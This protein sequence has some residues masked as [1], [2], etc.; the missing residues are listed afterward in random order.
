MCEQ[1]RQTDKGLRTVEE[2][3]TETAAP[4]FFYP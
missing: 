2:L 3:P 4:F 1:K